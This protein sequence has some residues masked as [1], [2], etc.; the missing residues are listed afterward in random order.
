[1][2]TILDENDVVLFSDP[3]KTY[4]FKEKQRVKVSFRLTDYLVT[5]IELTQETFEFIL[6]HWKINKGIRGLKTL[7]H[8]QISW[9]YSTCGPRPARVP[10][11]MVCINFSGFDFRISLKEMERVTENYYHQKDNKMHWDA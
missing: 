4:L 8:G 6:G 3:I 2:P 11:S 7:H 1:M 9:A 10:A 5:N